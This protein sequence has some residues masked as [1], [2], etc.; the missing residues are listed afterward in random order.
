V[1][2]FGI[3][4]IDAV[5]VPTVPDM[6]SDEFADANNQVRFLGEENS[7]VRT[8]DQTEIGIYWGYDVARGPG[9]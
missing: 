7:S 5:P 1:T 8:T 9:R 2:T 4:S 3:P 6:S